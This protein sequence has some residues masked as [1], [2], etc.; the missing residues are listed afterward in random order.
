MPEAASKVLQKEIINLRKVVKGSK[1]ARRVT[2]D[3][4]IPI[5]EKLDPIID[6][7]LDWMGFLL[8]DEIQYLLSTASPG[9][10]YDVYYV[11]TSMPWGQKATKVGQYTSSE[12]GG[13]PK[14]PRGGGN[15]D[16][17]QSGTL[18]KSIVYKIEEDTITVGIEDKQTPY[19]IWYGWGKIF[20]FANP[21][22]T[23]PQKT[24]TQYG[25][26]LD[27]PE[28][29]SYRPYFTSAI[30]NVRPQLKKRFREEFKKGLNEATKRPTV[31]RAVEIHFIW[32]TV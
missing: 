27:S 30:A 3:I 23:T 10:T 16:F 14:S 1:L 21:K 9:F 20:V 25:S 6:E 15:L 17:P 28:Y 11:D 29:E 13:P 19:R 26:I 7:M 31:K 22:W 12:R 18:Y 32:K 4:L 8:Q 2:E 5:L 24:T